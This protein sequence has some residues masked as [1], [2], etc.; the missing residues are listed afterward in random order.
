MKLKEPLTGFIHLIGA[1]LT[2]PAIVL[3]III[4]HDSV[5]KVVSFSIYGSSFFLLFTFSTL[6]HWLPQSAGGR[7]QIF[8]KLDHLA[9]YL[10][11]AGTYTPFCLNT[12][13][14]QLGWTILATIWTM[15]L[16][17][18]IVQSVYINV[19]RWLTTLIYIIM[20]WM[21][22]L[23]FKPLL[24]VMPAEGIAWLVAGGVIY[25]VGGVMYALRKPNLSE[26]FGFH[27]L[28]HAMVLLAAA[29][30]YIAVLLYVAL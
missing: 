14:G 9:I 28:W 26:R 5:W 18:M 6:Y 23:A 13:R 4:G 12:L 10:V 27:E 19:W 24:S 22:I 25:S 2:V 15:A 8:R 20:G 7:F 16:L 29:C 30:H 17:G 21:I 11:I 3:L 1:V